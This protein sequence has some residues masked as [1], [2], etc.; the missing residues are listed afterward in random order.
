MLAFCCLLF[1]I[2]FILCSPDHLIFD[3]TAQDSDSMSV[4]GVT[5]DCTLALT[6][7]YEIHCAIQPKKQIVAIWP[8]ECLRSYSYGSGLFSI[9]AGRHSPHGPG[10]FSFI[11]S[12]D[13]LIHD[14]LER[15]IYKARRNSSSSE[16]SSRFSVSDRPPARLPNDDQDTSSESPISTANSD[17]DFE[18]VDNSH[19]KNAS[20]Q[21]VFE[22]SSGQEDVLPAMPPPVFGLPP[23][24]PPK[25]V[26]KT[27]SIESNSQ[28]LNMRFGPSLEG[29]TGL[30]Q[31]Q[32]P[33]GSESSEDHVYSHTLH[34]FPTGSDPLSPTSP[35]C[36]S[37]YNS[38]VR[39]GAS[40][41]TSPTNNEK[42]VYDV[43]YP[44]QGLAHNP[45]YDLAYTKERVSPPVIRTKDEADFSPPRPPKF[46]DGGMTTNPLY[47]SKSNLFDDIVQHVS[48]LPSPPS[49]QHLISPPVKHE[50]KA[51]VPPKT[52]VPDVTAN[53]VYVTSTIRGEQPLTGSVCQPISL[54][55]T[56]VTSTSNRYTTL[57]Q[58]DSS[59]VEG[60]VSDAS[61]SAVYTPEKDF[62]GYTKITK[63]S[64]SP[65]PQSPERNHGRS[66]PSRS[67][68][69]G[70]FPVSSSLESEP[71]PVPE[72]LYDV[73]H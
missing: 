63:T 6:S 5:G 30:Q 62:K 23:K 36:P 72:R 38:L 2:S 43:A 4:I 69:S 66:P 3:V 71:P 8:F 45:E 26:T 28:W 40:S 50:T 16:L 1:D 56:S 61:S 51:T 73:D 15:L 70:S 14:Q 9:E 48:S 35:S 68:S 60:M 42:M 58:Q 10:E 57:Q 32:A 7:N 67:S 55:A 12:Q 54:P 20:D 59:G 37:I 53:P 46:T 44:N 39:E 22:S 49:Q 17:S 18:H 27:S 34:Q 21:D 47:G 13:K 29:D 33:V 41:A 24:L 19:Q 31:R 25:G 52:V 65:M 64:V 11:T